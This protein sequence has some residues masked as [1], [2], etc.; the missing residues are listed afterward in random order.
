MGRYMD[1]VTY[2]ATPDVVSYAQ[3]RETIA[4]ILEDPHQIESLVSVTNR[5]RTL[6]NLTT[7]SKR[8]ADVFD[9]LL[10]YQID[11]P[12]SPLTPDIGDAASHFCLHILQDLQEMIEPQNLV[13]LFTLTLSICLYSSKHSLHRQLAK[14]LIECGDALESLAS[15]AQGS[16][17]IQRWAVSSKTTIYHSNIIHGWTSRLVD[18]TRRCLDQHKSS[19][20][21]ESW[22]NLML[23]ILGLEAINDRE[24]RLGDILCDEGMATVVKGVISHQKSTP[25]RSI[26]IPMNVLTGLRDHGLAIPESLLGVQTALETLKTDK[27]SEI[28]IG[29]ANTFPCRICAK[30]ITFPQ[31]SQSITV[32]QASFERSVQHHN[33]DFAIF[34]ISEGAWRIVLSELALKTLR[35]LAQDEL[36]PVRNKLNDLAAGLWEFHPIIRG[37]KGEKL[38]IPFST[39]KCYRAGPKDI[40]ILWH[41]DLSPS[42]DSAGTKQCIRV[43]EIGKEREVMN[44]VPK[45]ALLHQN[46]SKEAVD[47][48]TS[49]PM[50]FKHRFIPLFQPLA[51]SK[52]T[53]QR[54]SAKLDMRTADQAIIEMAHKWYPLTDAVLK[55][56][57]EK[58]LTAEFPFELSQEEMHVISHVKSPS[59]ILGRSGTGKTTCLAKKLVGKYIA[60]MKL[61]G[62]RP[63]QQVLLTRSGLLVEKLF[64]YTRDLIR[65]LGP[66]TSQPTMVTKTSQFAGSAAPLYRMDVTQLEA[67]MFPLVCTFDD[68][69]SMLENTVVALDRQ[70]DMSSEGR[71]RNGRLVKVDFNRFRTD[72]WP[73]LP[74]KTRHDFAVDAVFPEIMGVIKG[75]TD[76]SLSL[77]PLSRDQYNNMSARKAPTFS[78][79]DR[80]RIYDI[81][82]AY[83]QMKS[84]NGHTDD[85]D[86][87][88]KLLVCIRTNETIRSTLRS[89]FSEVYIDEVQDHRCVDLELFLA[90][91]DDKRGFHFAGDTAQTIALDTSFRFEDARTLFSQA[92]PNGI[93]EK[94]RKHLLP[95]NFNLS[96]NFRSHQGILNLAGLVM[97]MLWNGFPSFID[98]LEPETGIMNGPK[99]VLFLRCDANI[100]RSRSVGL[101]ELSQR[102][103][104]FG[105]EQ[106]ILVRNQDEKR[107]LQAEIGDI[108]LIL[109]ILEAKGMEFDD[110]I[111]WHFF[112]NSAHQTSFR[113]I[114][115][116][117]G[118]LPSE[119]GRNHPQMCLEL[120]L[121]YV[122][123]TRARFRL[124]FFERSDKEI[125]SVC[126]LL[127]NA[128]EE[129]LVETTRPSQ[130]DFNRKLATIEPSK[131]NDPNKWK[132]QGWR[133]MAYKHYDA[134]VLCFRKAF[135]V[136]AEQEATAHS[137]EEKGIELES[138]GKVGEARQFYSKAAS[139]LRELKK[140]KDATRILEERLKDLAS[141]ASLWEEAGEL[142]KAAPLFE[143]AQLYSEAAGCYTSM[144]MYEEGLGCLRRGACFDDFVMYLS[145]H[146]ESFA[147]ITVQRNSQLCRL[148]LK[149]RKIS[150]TC[151]KYAIRA[152]GSPEEQ[153]AGLVEYDLHEDL[154]AFYEQQMR[155]VD[156]FRLRIRQ[157]RLLEA[158][159]LSICQRLCEESAPEVQA[160][161]RKL[162]T[163]ICAQNLWA[164]WGAKSA[165]FKVP[166]EDKY[167]KHADLAN[168]A[169]LWQ[170][171][172]SVSTAELSGYLDT[173]EDATVEICTTIFVLSNETSVWQTVDFLALP[174]ALLSRAIT[175]AGQLT[176]ST[177]VEAVSIVRLLG[178][179]WQTDEQSPP[180][181]SG[182]SVFAPECGFDTRSVDLEAAKHKI[183]EVTSTA[184]L[185][186][187]DCARGLWDL[188]WPSRCRHFLSLGYCP[189]KRQGQDCPFLH[190]SMTSQDCSDRIADLLSFTCLL[191]N[192]NRL[193]LSRAMSEAFNGSFLPIRRRW[194]ER[195]LRELTFVSACDQDATQVNSGWQQLLADR[196]LTVVKSSLE[197]LL[198]HRLGRQWASNK[199]Y[200]AIHEQLQMASCFGRAVQGRFF[201]NLSNKLYNEPRSGPVYHD[202]RRYLQLQCNFHE[203]PAVAVKEHID[204][205]LGVLFTIHE[206]QLATLPGL[207]SR[208]ELLCFY[209]I[210]RLRGRY[211][212]LPTSWIE[213][214]L[215][216][217]PREA[218]EHYIVPERDNQVYRQC[219][220]KL[221][222][223]FCRLLLFFDRQLRGPGFTLMCCGVRLQERYLQ[224]RNTNMILTCIANLGLQVGLSGEMVNM[225]NN[226]LTLGSMRASH[227]CFKT[228]SELMQRALMLSF[229]MYE[230]KDTLLLVIDQSKHYPSLKHLH[231]LENHPDVVKTTPQDL[232]SRISSDVLSAAPDQ[233]GATEQQYSEADLKA[234]TIVQRLWKTRRPGVLR[235]RQW[236]QTFEGKLAT[237]FKDAVMRQASP[238]VTGWRLRIDGIMVARAVQALRNTISTFRQKALNLLSTIG[239][240]EE[241][242]EDLDSQIQ[243]L[244][245]YER[246]LMAIAERLTGQ[247]L[248]QLL[249]RPEQVKDTLKSFLTDT[250]EI[251]KGMPEIKRAIRKGEKKTA[252]AKPTTKAKE[253][254][255]Q[256]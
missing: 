191:C 98:K 207:T 25:E 214:H 205:F 78:D 52:R 239:L 45:A 133:L 152:L 232:Q 175:F 235:Q 93:S 199:T 21:I 137:N 200:S 94:A 248:I 76:S 82:E 34:G 195:L 36:A 196:G 229:E 178:G 202:L 20:L 201:R 5:D 72:Y 231:G 44:V 141:A 43:W 150:A 92:L 254:Q 64:L 185:K 147:T 113:R 149:Q 40:L 188:R 146:Y 238:V 69:L 38:L 53:M 91:I 107:N 170:E 128:Y 183:L 59:L 23:L 180:I 213:C 129:P 89:V 116:L 3:Q 110:V 153:E 33:L 95:R 77:E 71:G 172:S 242:N 127:D 16:A 134:A 171:I 103:A 12:K 81:F 58:D 120:K 206:D 123:I 99:P 14:L 189:S 246:K 41:I 157:G 142:D 13:Q 222:D 29:I 39:T 117:M 66:D 166:V 17:L 31:K 121:L 19:S 161:T 74:D 8:L 158:L 112:S 83:E 56:L 60:S 176:D 106:V 100:I 10:K 125:T 75:S 184:I 204:D 197:D 108:G 159:E 46:Y 80:D 97:T 109:T 208:F 210:L 32:H 90:F 96:T 193:Y 115:A 26:T 243:A 104:D 18:L 247:G 237:N 198:Y 226:V 130:S 135:D 251:Q 168:I 131:T 160:L 105:A 101:S 154:E 227:M 126:Q 209:M 187:D 181:V 211:C 7:Q 255:K 49:N 122:A 68:L 233:G 163:F 62:D 252:S 234:I 215:P 111:I 48:C 253:E 15:D 192:A 102:S 65:T 55:A 241:N 155:F 42:T 57:A 124:F 35:R 145:H 61:G 224:R 51:D 217:L 167:S 236:L 37:Q 84:Q 220:L 1:L 47:L 249:E 85:V 244:S 151:R 4:A 67:D 27:T 87:I 190:E 221:V 114:G 230:A 225:V 70:R 24:R 22:D 54:Q 164:F 143:Q 169:K 156:L 212:L 132:A 194:L 165:D 50:K 218:L 11:H 245:Q 182:T 88:F 63:I 79:E 119:F 177:N 73:R 6:L 240:Q 203:V 28:L 250:H 139:A 173:L 136:K 138:K 256:D 174:I 148:L 140:V 2:L 30:C 144:S 86:H 9:S 186:I 223:H 118:Q 216:H 228:S 179:I 219:L 162:F